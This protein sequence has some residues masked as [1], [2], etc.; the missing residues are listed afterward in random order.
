MAVAERSRRRGKRKS[1]RQ[2]FLGGSQPASQRQSGAGKH[3][4]AHFP[5][6]KSSENI[7]F[8][9]ATAAETAVGWELGGGSRTASRLY[10]LTM[11]LAVIYI[12]H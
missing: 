8:V 3:M 9:S 5:L 12:T 4:K 2:S 10:L 7:P 11:L 6:I 1:D